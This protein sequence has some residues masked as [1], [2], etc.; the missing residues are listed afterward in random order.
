MGEGVGR[1]GLVAVGP[2]IGVGCGSGVPL[3]VQLEG[4]VECCKL[5]IEVLQ[6][7]HYEVMKFCHMGNFCNTMKKINYDGRNMNS[8]VVPTCRY[9]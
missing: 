7:Y 5:H 4:M 9:Y 1:G 3:P 2:G 8:P 6:L